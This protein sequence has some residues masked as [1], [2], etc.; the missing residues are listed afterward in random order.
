MSTLLAENAVLQELIETRT[1][2]NQA[3]QPIS[4]HSNIPLPF[5]EALYQTVLAQRPAIAIEIGMAFGISTLSILTALRS[6]NG[7]RLISIDPVQSSTWQGCGAAA[8]ERA[9]L[10]YFHQLIEEP[11]YTALPQL[12][13]TGC[14]VDFAY[15]DG[16]HTFDYTLLDFWYLDKM[17]Q[18]GGIVG[19]NDCDWPAID[20]AIRF[21]LSHRRYEEVNVGLRSIEPTAQCPCEDRY[22]RKLEHWEPKWD[23]F[24]EF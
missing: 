13:R 22:F 11:D 8:V 10:Q 16:W 21:V 12:L 14:Q 23:F 15:I 6:L 1:A 5:A 24:A 9:G 20:K 18:V 17:M 3:G 4:M 2:Y 19:F 7:G